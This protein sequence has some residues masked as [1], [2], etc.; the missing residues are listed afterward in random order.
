MRIQS[1][2][3]KGLELPSLL[4]DRAAGG[5]TSPKTPTPAV[6]TRGA[7]GEPQQP[8]QSSMQRSVLQQQGLEKPRWISALNIL[9]VEVHSTYRTKYS[10]QFL[11]LLTKSQGN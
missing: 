9:Y 5:F 11:P 2:G 1:G 6:T 4:A 10:F 7:P 3:K 8:K